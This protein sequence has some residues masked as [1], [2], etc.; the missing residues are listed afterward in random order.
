MT[1][2]ISADGIGAEKKWEDAMKQRIVKAGVLA[3]TMAGASA[4]VAQQ[5]P[6]DGA[7]RTA[8]SHSGQAPAARPVFDPGGT[9]HVPAFDLPPSPFLSPEALAQQKA[10][11]AMPVVDRLVG[12]S[13]ADLRAMTERLLAPRVVEMQ[14]RYPVDIV[15]QQ[16]GGVRT[17]VVTPKGGRR[18]PAACS[19][20]CMAAG[21]A[22]ARK[23]ARWS[24]PSPLPRSAVSEW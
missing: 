7:A 18:T 5:R 2:T 6:K 20:T 13:I 24:N 21:S 10:R 3:I 23:G 15:E 16:I 14:Q 4:L 22:N 19:S 1:H 9:V 17:R 12:T 11:A 8:P